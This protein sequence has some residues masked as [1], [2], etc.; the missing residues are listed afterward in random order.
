MIV[1]VSLVKLRP[2]LGRDQVR[3]LWLGSHADLVRAS[4]SVSRYV[5]SFAEGDRGPEQW[6]AIAILEF[7][8]RAELESWL[9]DEALQAELARTREPFIERVEAFV[10]ESHQVIPAESQGQCP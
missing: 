2:G 10:V 7:P 8:A 1:R 3:R 6:D 9:A 4:P 5:V